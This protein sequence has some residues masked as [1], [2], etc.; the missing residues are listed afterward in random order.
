VEMI[1]G[2]A[3]A[4]KGAPMHAEGARSTK[5]TGARVRQSGAH[6]GHKSGPSASS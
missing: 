2:V 6:G 4:A 1:P 3:S 5:A